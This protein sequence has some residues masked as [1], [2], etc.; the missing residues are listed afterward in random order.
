MTLEEEERKLARN[1]REKLRLREKRG[2]LKGNLS[3]QEKLVKI[4]AQNKKKREY[5][6]DRQRKIRAEETRLVQQILS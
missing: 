2:G 3:E 5:N 1:E 6:R 4:V